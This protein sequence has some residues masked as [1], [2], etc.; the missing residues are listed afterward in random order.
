MNIMNIW[1]NDIL[2]L[3]FQGKFENQRKLSEQS[4]YSLGTVNQSIRYLFENGYI[5]SNNNITSKTIDYIENK[6]VKRA[7]ILAAGYGMRMVPINT[8]VPKGLI[9]VNGETL[10]ERIIKS[11]L[12]F[13]I[14]PL[15]IPKNSNLS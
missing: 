7:V 5:D 15:R 1:E 4:G 10:I 14:L 9:E 3:L 11:L 13:L 12:K 6:K 2:Y 8:E